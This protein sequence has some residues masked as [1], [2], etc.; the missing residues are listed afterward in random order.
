MDGRDEVGIERAEGV[1]WII[2][3]WTNKFRVDL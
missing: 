3:H 2:W 1:I